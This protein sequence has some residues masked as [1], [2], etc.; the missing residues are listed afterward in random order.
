MA[1]KNFGLKDGDLDTIIAILKKYPQVEQA[2]IFGSR[3]K[4][5]Y[6][7]GS[8]VDIVIK[9]NVEE[10]ITDVSFSLNEDS[11][12]PYKFDVLDYNNISSQDLIDHINRVGIVF[13]EKKRDERDKKDQIQ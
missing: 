9:G 1:L 7:P 3:A 4:G 11:L 2:L 12:L 6:K 5:N 13:Y 10:I 8:D